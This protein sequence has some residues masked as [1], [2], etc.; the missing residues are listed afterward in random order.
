MIANID[1]VEY[2]TLNCRDGKIIES[3]EEWSEL[4]RKDIDAENETNTWII[5][6][7]V[8]YSDLNNGREIDINGHDYQYKTVCEALTAKDMF[9]AFI[10]EGMYDELFDALN[11]I[12]EETMQKIIKHMPSISKVGEKYTM[13]I[14]Q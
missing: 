12:D 5:Q 7:S 11:K 9:N 6:P 14:C 3:Q 4:L 1:N 2:K 8:Y 13:E 10:E